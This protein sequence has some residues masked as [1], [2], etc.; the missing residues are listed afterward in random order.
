MMKVVCR[1]MKKR[2]VVSTTT[3]AMRISAYFHRMLRLIH[4]PTNTRLRLPLTK[5]SAIPSVMSALK[6]PLKVLIRRLL[7]VWSRRA[8]ASL[9]ALKKSKTPLRLSRKMLPVAVTHLPRS[10]RAVI[11]ILTITQS[12][13]SIVLIR[14]R[15][16]MLSASKSAATTRP[17]ITSFVVS[18]T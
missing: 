15:A 12:R 11:V 6:A 3:E 14:V 1:L 7:V 8:K 4:R 9:T 13:S 10:S 5:V 18:S 2:C 16:L 17:A